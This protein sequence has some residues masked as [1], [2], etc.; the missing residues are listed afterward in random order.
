MQA[1]GPAKIVASPWRA[2]LGPVDKA[3]KSRM[4]NCYVRDKHVGWL[5]FQSAADKARYDLVNNVPIARYAECI[6]AF[7]DKYDG[8]RDVAVVETN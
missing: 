1:G 5:E 2:D 6:A 8:F 7:R 4:L 3:R